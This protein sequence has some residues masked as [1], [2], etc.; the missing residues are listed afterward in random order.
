VSFGLKTVKKK[1]R[2]CKKTK[3]R[4]IALMIKRE[5]TV[6]TIQRYNEVVPKKKKKKKK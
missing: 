6:Q 5:K 2:A 3:A 1:N 4:R